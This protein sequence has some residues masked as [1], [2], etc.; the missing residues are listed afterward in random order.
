M[1]ATS[2][3]SSENQIFKILCWFAAI[4]PVIVLLTAMIEA[5]L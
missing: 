4:G 5:I 1:K 2:N 3:K